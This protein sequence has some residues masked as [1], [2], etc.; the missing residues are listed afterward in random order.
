[1][2]TKSLGATFVG[3]EQSTL[4]QLNFAHNKTLYL[5]LK[6]TGDLWSVEKTVVLN[7][8]RPRED[9]P[10]ESEIPIP[11]SIPQA[12]KLGALRETLANKFNAPISR[13]V[14]LKVVNNKPVVMQGETKDLLDDFDITEG[15]TLYCEQIP[16]SLTEK[17]MAEWKPIVVNQIEQAQNMI[18]LCFNLPDEI[19]TDQEILVDK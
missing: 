11:V 5:E 7:V 19:S 10:Y 13:T 2:F 3:K 9:H 16:D 17:Q 4:S 8:I 15:S 14:I 18:E 1:M 12:S 6:E